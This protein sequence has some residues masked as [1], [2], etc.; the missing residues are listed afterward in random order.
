MLWIF[1]KKLL[2]VDND[3]IFYQIFNT[4]NIFNDDNN[5]IFNLEN[6]NLIFKDF[7]DYKNIKINYEIKIMG[8]IIS[9][10]KLDDN[11]ILTFTKQE[12]HN[13]S[14]N[15]ILTHEYKLI[16]NNRL[17]ELSSYDY[18]YLNIE[19]DIYYRDY[20]KLFIIQNNKSN[21]STTNYWIQNSI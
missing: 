3:L 18:H 19:F 15:L 13:I 20:T 17:P 11:E 16:D 14:D 8:N 4:N 12:S 2:E 7:K 6:N 10:K 1:N 5:K 21:N 9:Y